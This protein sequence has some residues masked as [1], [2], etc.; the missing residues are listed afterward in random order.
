MSAADT[1][2]KRQGTSC[3]TEILRIGTLADLRALEVLENRAFS[4]D[5]LCRRSFARFLTSPNA[6][7]L[8][9]A[10][11]GVLYGYALVLFRSGSQAARLYSLA[12]DPSCR[13][14]GLGTEL[15][16]AAEE[17]ARSRGAGVMRLELREDNDSAANLYRWSGY[18]KIK[19]ISRYYEDAGGALRLENPLGL[20]VMQ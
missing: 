12:V 15:L 6:S 18:R 5:R 20:Q 13:R 1:L 19:R 9:G 2:L 8:V 4:G 14:C 3:R 17:A 7:L 10:Q 16:T 11:A